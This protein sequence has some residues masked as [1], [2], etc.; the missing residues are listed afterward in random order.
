MKNILSIIIVLG[1]PF[2]YG[3]TEK[4]LDFKI[5]YAP[6]TTYHQIVEQSSDNE[7]YYEG[8]DE[9]LKKLK[10]NGVENPTISKSLTLVES[11][12]KTGKT[13]K[14]GNFSVIIE[15]LNA[16]N[17]EQKVII[18]SGTL[19][20]GNA[21]MATMPKLDSIVSKDLDENFKK[22]LLQTVQSTFSQ[23]DL[24]SQKMKL[25]ESFSQESPLN[26]PLAGLTLEMI[27]NTTY[28]LMKIADENADF[29]IL[30]TYTIKLSDQKYN[31]NASGNG[32]GNL[33]YDIP[34]HFPVRFNLDIALNLALKQEAFG[35]KVKSKS[36]FSQNVQIAK[37]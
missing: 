10:D 7:L 27:I 6:Q 3:Q 1:S 34:N 2:I 8:A 18:P 33:L 19:I 32:N 35:L 23:I 5:G 13:E 21:S 26:L 25:G 20:Y 4:I 28:K 14:S 30:Q 16:R 29:D 9:L 37:N 31:I 36:G 17:S 15:F 11:V 12:V 22:K 24:P